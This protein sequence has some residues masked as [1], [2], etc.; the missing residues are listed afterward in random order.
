MAKIQAF[1]EL[2][3]SGGQVHGPVLCGWK[4]FED[5]GAAF[6]Q[7]DTYGSDARKLTGKVS[8]SIQFD[9]ASA[10]ELLGV[11]RRAFPTLFGTGQC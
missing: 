4:I 9:Q 7:L 10:S 11:L 2:P 5:A 6:L 1:E 8:Q 3:P